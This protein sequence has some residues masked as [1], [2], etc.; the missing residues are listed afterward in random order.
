MTYRDAD[1]LG[2]ANGLPLRARGV[3]AKGKDDGSDGVTEARGIFPA[4]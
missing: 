3:A 4:R 2:A 1:L